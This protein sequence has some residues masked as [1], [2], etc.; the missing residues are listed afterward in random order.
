MKWQQPNNKIHYHTVN[1]NSQ[2]LPDNLL[3][4]TKY[5]MAYDIY[6]E[7]TNKYTHHWNQV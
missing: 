2:E 3:T 4:E 5:I 1:K 6:L 7:S